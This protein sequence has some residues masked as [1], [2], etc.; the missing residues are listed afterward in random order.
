MTSTPE[1]HNHA[2]ATGKAP[3]VAINVS[4]KVAPVPLDY[5]TSIEEILR[6]VNF[7]KR[8]DKEQ[9]LVL[10]EAGG[11]QG[12]AAKLATD[13]S[14]G[15]GADDDLASREAKFGKNVVPPP[16]SKT[17]FELIIDSFGDRILQI[18]LAGALVTLI[19]GLAK[20]DHGW[21]D[22]VAIFMAVAIV[23]TVVAGNDYS[24]EKKFKALL[25][26]QS[27]KKVKLIRAGLKDQRSS[28]DLLA[29]DVV[30]LQ[31]GD[32]IP[33]DGMFIDGINVSVDESPLT[34]ES[35]PVKKSAK[36]PFMFSGCQVNEG[37]CTMLVTTV[38]QYSTGGQIQKLLSDQQSE[39]TP[40]QEKLDL[41]ATQ[42][43]YVGF[44]AGFITFLALTINWA[45]DIADDFEADDLVDIVDFF[46]IG[47]TIVVVCVP[48]G[49]PL[50][51]TISLAYSMMKM[52]SEKNFVRHLDASETMGSATN[53]CS[54]K[55]GTL[56]ENRMTVT[57]FYTP[58]ESEFVDFNAASFPEKIRN[59]LVQSV[60][61]NSTCFVKYESANGFPTFVGS[62]TEGAMLVLS[63]K[64]G[65]DYEALRKEFPKVAGVDYAFSSARKRM[66]TL[67]HVSNGATPY[68][69]H[70]KGAS[71]IVLGL[72][73]T[74]I[75]ASGEILPLEKNKDMILTNITR[76]A[77]LGLRTLV[78][79]YKD[80]TAIPGEEED[81]ENNLTFIGLI[82]IKDPLRKEVPE[83]VKTCQR[84]GIVVRMV[85][86]DNI[87]T[88]TTIARECGILTDND[89][90][91]EGP[92]FRELTD[93]QKDE[94]IPKIRVLARSSP[95]DKFELVT[96]LKKMGEVVAVTGDG[97]NDA[98]ALKEAD[99]GFSMGIAGTQIAMNA[100]DIVLLDDNFSSI[101][102]AIR[103]GRNVFDCIQKFIQFQLAVN[104][105]AVF[106]V[107]LGSVI[108]GE[109]PLSPV[110]LLWVNL[111]MDT[112]GALALATDPPEDS[113]LLRK[114][115]KRTDHLITRS[116]FNYIVTQF[117]FQVFVLL[118]VRYEMS[119]WLG[120]ERTDTEGD[121]EKAASGGDTPT[122]KDDID[123][124][125]TL[126]FT[127]FVILQ[128]FNEMLAHNINNP[129]NV[130]YGFLRNPMFGIILV[131]IAGIQIIVVQFGGAFAKTVPLSPTEWG[132]CLA[133]SALSLPYGAAVRLV[134]KIQRDM[135]KTEG[136][137][138]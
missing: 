95:A 113:I 51:V 84:A 30:E 107:F 72:C 130:F 7:D 40:L 71:E 13:L 127:T 23:V 128:L 110:Q 112:L 74:Y 17:I 77:K 39:A 135:K 80:I 58:G 41:L 102:K 79:G 16:P 120:F 32:E 9:I 37:S 98:P 137:N 115:N 89:L 104:M 48:E 105:T 124:I 55:T 133:I 97:T 91:M 5:G 26:M 15:L 87:L 68:R 67:V 131:V 22:G 69:L 76:M 59:I 65:A 10:D 8:D 134:G 136:G 101:V 83:A 132:A 33:A 34:G 3:H 36:Q 29:G 54:D 4:S 118:F 103:W 100:S 78:V 62:S 19:I 64:L 2:A 66:S 92:K 18:L 20:Q 93:S 42:I 44:V 108:D 129:I 24:K 106:I 70:T 21:I 53:I 11:I 52:I 94:V 88:A 49:L 85:T 81:P 111:I 6:I 25:M 116:M 138:E 38:G 57:N 75:S 1:A 43:G 12:M 60:S 109:S 28:W 47:I 114:P 126:V 90:A 121:N 56:T 45:V 50:A 31:Q 96:R 27:D 35:I 82:G 86:G 122:R 14:R 123:V 117:L 63:G 73:E 61:V 119:E 125:H 46:V 99:V